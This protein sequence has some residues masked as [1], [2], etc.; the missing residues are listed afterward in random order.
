M[1]VKGFYCPFIPHDKRYIERFYV[2]IHDLPD[3]D[4][5][6]FM[7]SVRVVLL[8][9]VSIVVII[10]GETTTEKKSI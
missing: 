2:L 1:N 6:L 3:F 7:V 10:R 8:S 9:L 4:I 5:L